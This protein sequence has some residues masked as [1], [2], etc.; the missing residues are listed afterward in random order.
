MTM[1]FYAKEILPISKNARKYKTIF[2]LFVFYLDTYATTVR[3]PIYLL[4]SI[5][6]T[7]YYNLL[8]SR[9]KYRKMLLT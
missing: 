3:L 2:I 1:K 4:N 5:L 7:I 9:A 8:E 6:N